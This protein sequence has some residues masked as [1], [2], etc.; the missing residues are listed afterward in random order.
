MVVHAKAPDITDGTASA[1]SQLYA[2]DQLLEQLLQAGS[3]EEVSE[4]GIK[5]T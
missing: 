5:P 1:A 4:R 3:Q 2:R